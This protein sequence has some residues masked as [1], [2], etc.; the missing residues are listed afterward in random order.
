MVLVVHRRAGKTTA[1]L[2]FLQR[3]ALTKRNTRY[4][5]IA[6]TYK[7]AKGVAW[8]NLKKYSLFIPGIEHRESDLTVVYPNGSKITLYG[9]ENP[10]RLRGLGLAGVVFDEYGQQPDNIFSEVIRPSL[11]ENVGYAIWIGTPQGKNG[12]YHLYEEHKHDQDWYTCLLTVEDT[13]VI[14]AE[15]IINSKQTMSQEEYLQELYCSFESAV[16]G[17]VYAEE[18]RRAREEG[19]IGIFQFYR[20][21]KVYTVWDIGVGQALAVGFYQSMHGQVRMIDYWQGRESDGIDQ[22]VRMVLQKPYIY[23][24]HFAPHDMNAREMSTGKTRLDFA[25]NLGLNFNVLPPNNPDDG[26]QAGK[27]LFNRMIID[28]EKCAKWLEAILEYKQ[29]WDDRRGMYKEV[30]FHDWTSHA[31]DVHRYAALAEPRMIETPQRAFIAEPEEE[32]WG[33]DDPYY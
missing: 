27:F 2:N 12:F 5:Y 7:M 32:G 16:K 10:D 1:A 24:M 11:M 29:V 22:A 18:L 21:Q 4:A 33:D 26:I 23:G 17:A 3:S 13:N 25:R 14:S 31:A 20:E 15:E 8:D 28:E 19:R 30:P 9:A 6:P